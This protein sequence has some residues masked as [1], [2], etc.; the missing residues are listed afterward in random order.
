MPGG[1]EIVIT[2]SNLEVDEEM[3]PANIDLRPGRYVAISMSDT[4]E[5]MQPEVLER[6]FEPFFTTKDVGKGTGLGLSTVYGFAKQSNGGVSIYSEPTRG[7]TVN[8]YLPAAEGEVPHP[9]NSEPEVE[10]EAKSQR[11]TI[12]VVED[13]PQV[14]THVERTLARLGYVVQ[15]AQDAAAALALLKRGAAFDLLFTDIIMPGGMNGQELGEAAHQ[16][17]PE[18]KILF[19]SGYP[20]AAFE[21]L[22]LKEQSSIS[23]LSKPYKAVELQ[24]TLSDIFG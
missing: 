13:Q 3:V 16:I 18:M 17:A 8:L 9:G 20:A 22:G 6:A 1:G 24:R 2:C 15:T 23:F 12:L 14:R 4:G 10:T 11:K 19:T 5:G 21:H 7:T